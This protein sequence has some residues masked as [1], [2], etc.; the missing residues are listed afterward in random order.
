VDPAGRITAGGLALV[1]AAALAACNGGSDPGPGGRS[2]EPD[3]TASPTV[4]FDD[5]VAAVEERVEVYDEITTGV[6]ALV[7]KDDETEVVTNGRSEV[8]DRVPPAPGDTFPIASITKPMTAALVLQLVGDGEVALGDPARRWLPELRPVDAEIT[9][10]QLLSH[11]SGLSETVEADV[12]Q[13]GFDTA[14]LLERSARRPLDFR[15][16]SD[17][18]YAN[19]GYGALGL[20]VERVLGQPFGTAL[21]ER[22]FRP[23]GMKDSSLGGR[24]EVQGHQGN[25]KPVEKYYLGF[26]PGAGS[27]V[28]TAADVD[29]FFRALWAGELLDL[30]EVD[31]MRT[32]RGSLQFW[33]EYGLGLAFEKFT[34]GRAIGHSGRIAGFTIEAWTLAGEER[35]TVVMVND[36]AADTVVNSIVETALCS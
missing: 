23:A 22:V 21:E 14:A 17:G 12:R 28:A 6:I 10:E 19:I 2:G 31:E 8:T 27:V 18:S 13:V 5:V 1:L 20:L 29:G 24:P 3:A 36:E 9:V 34:C 11:R 16:G 25:G 26:L 32:P 30:D 7:R 33:S 4:S 15:P 35:S